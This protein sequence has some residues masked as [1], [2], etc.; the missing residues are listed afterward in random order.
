MVLVFGVDIPLFEFLLVFM[1]LLT[2]GLI[3]VLM[4]LKRLSEYLLIERSDLKRLE[5]DLGIL[6]TEE[7]R[8]GEEEAR[9]G[10]VVPVPPRK[11]A[12][13]RARTKKPVKRKA[14]G[15]RARR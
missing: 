5:R 6:E 8:L 1:V 7:R 4:E 13:K 11:R 14:A 12:K 2:A 15:K 3:F 9:L 10:V